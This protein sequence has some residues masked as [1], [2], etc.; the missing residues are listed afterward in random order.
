VD[1]LGGLF[2]GGPLF[3]SL[4][5]VAVLAKELDVVKCSFSMFG[6]RV[7]GLFFVCGLRGSEQSVGGFV[8]ALDGVQSSTQGSFGDVVRSIV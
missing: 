5:D 8:V 2:S 7:V 6:N 3:T 4:V 1:C